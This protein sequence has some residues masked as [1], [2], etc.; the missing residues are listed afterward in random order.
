MF[1]VNIISLASSYTSP[2]SCSLC[3]GS[4]CLGSNR[5]EV[6]CG[7]NFVAMFGDLGGG[8]GGGR[9]SLT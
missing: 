5:G 3:L 8:S 6:L 9:S 7:L 1:L 4:L 2:S